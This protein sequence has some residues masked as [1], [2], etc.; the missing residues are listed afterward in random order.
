MFVFNYMQSIL[1]GSA[2]PGIIDFVIN[3]LKSCINIFAILLSLSVIINC[4]S[5]KKKIRRQDFYAISI[6]VLK[7]ALWIIDKDTI[8]IF[9]ATGEG[10]AAL[11]STLKSVVSGFVFTLSLYTLVINRLHDEDIVGVVKDF[12]WAF[13]LGILSLNC[14]LFLSA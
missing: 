10:L 12:Q 6:L 4:K 3:C 7:V 1:N 5:G 14:I 11:M 8:M 9:S 13:S 2:N